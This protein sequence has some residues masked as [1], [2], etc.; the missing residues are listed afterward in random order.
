MPATLFEALDLPL[1]SSLPP[2]LQHS[3]APGPPH[4]PGWTQNMGPL[5]R[6]AGAAMAGAAGAGSDGKG[7]DVG[8]PLAA[9]LQRQASLGMGGQRVGDGGL[10]GSGLGGAGAALGGVSA[11]G[12]AGAQRRLEVQLEAAKAVGDGEEWGV[13]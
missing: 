10:M 13:T 9:M 12:P 3:C 5:E 1:S 6:A 11:G 2:P 7:G 8:G 4:P